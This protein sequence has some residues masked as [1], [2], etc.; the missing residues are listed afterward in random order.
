MEDGHPLR[1]HHIMV[2]QRALQSCSRLQ[3]QALH[4]HTQICTFGSSCRRALCFFAHSTAELRTPRK[5]AEALHANVAAAADTSDAV[6]PSE[7]VTMLQ[8]QPDAL[9][10]EAAASDFTKAS[11]T[12]WGNCASSS[13]YSLPAASASTPGAILHLRSQQDHVQA[14]VQQ[15]PQHRQVPLQQPFISHHLAALQRAQLHLS[16]GAGPQVA[17]A[18]AAEN[19]VS[20]VSGNVA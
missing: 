20:I 3:H 7:W 1:E 14:H 15:Q 12:T 9:E 2:C 10:R 4:N 13:D 11:S 17:V 5:E 19:R 8:G 16:S 18:E 6:A